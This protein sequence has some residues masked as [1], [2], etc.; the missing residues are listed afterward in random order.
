MDIPFHD[1]S[2]TADF[3][4]RHEHAVRLILCDLGR[5]IDADFPPGLLDDIV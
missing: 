4:R 5:G 2:E 3:K 1:D